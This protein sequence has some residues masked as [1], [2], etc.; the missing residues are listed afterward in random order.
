MTT[1]SPLPLL[2]VDGLSMRFGSHTLFDRL[3]FSFDNGAVALVGA[4]GTGKS[5]MISLLCGIATLQAGVI[6]IGGHDISTQP[7]RAKQH[8]AYVP[9]EAV[10]YEFMT[11][12]QFLS[13]VDAL[14]GTCDAH[15]AVDLITGLGLDPHMGKRFDAMSLG[16]RKK[17][18]LVSG[19]MSQARLI[20]MDEPTNGLDSD[21]KQFLIRLI[22]HEAP[23]RLFF[24][25]THDSELMAGTGGQ[26]LRLGDC[27]ANSGKPPAPL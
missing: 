5:T 14:R 23:H 7:R 20:L 10:A 18:M 9:D 11:G 6:T 21:A 17:F 26:L 4:N 12:S 15:R 8:L 13:M 16:I 24:F 27:T 2:A 22:R 1:I 19:L 3:S 25:A